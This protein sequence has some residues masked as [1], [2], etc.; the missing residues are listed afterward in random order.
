[1]DADGA[2]LR[3]CGDP[4]EVVTRFGEDAARS[5]L[6]KRP[7]MLGRRPA[8]GAFAGLERHRTLRLPR[9][10]RIR[11]RWRGSTTGAG[12]YRWAI[13]REAAGANSKFALASSH[14]E[15]ASPAGARLVATGVAEGTS[16][17]PA[18]TESSSGGWSAGDSLALWVG[19]LE[20]SEAE[21]ARAPAGTAVEV[22]TTDFVCLHAGCDHA[23][24]EADAPLGGTL[25]T[26]RL[27]LCGV[28]AEPFEAARWASWA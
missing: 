15:R 28:G 8:G 17:A 22:A 20:R 26:H 25:P 14:S 18:L 19:R 2:A 16:D 3:L 4:D 6:A 1:V 10:G 21:E 5:A 9:G 7:S 11:A 24:A 23:A 13:T 12:R 27:E